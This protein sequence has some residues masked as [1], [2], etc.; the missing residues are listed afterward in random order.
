MRGEMTNYLLVLSSAWES[1]YD[2]N[3]KA[4]DTP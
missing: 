1:Y 4:V 2:Q 3:Q